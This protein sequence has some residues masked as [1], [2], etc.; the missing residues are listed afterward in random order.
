MG[1]FPVFGLVLGFATTVKSKA[2][3]MVDGLGRG[4]LI[5]MVNSGFIY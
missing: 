3:P 5:G 2:G 1:F 4:F